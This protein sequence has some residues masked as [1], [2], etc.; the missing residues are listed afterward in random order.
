MKKRWL[1]AVLACSF[2]L[3]AVTAQA[4][5]V[6]Y[7]SKTAQPQ[8]GESVTASDS[9]WTLRSPDGSISMTVNLE[10][11]GSLT[12]GAYLDG[13]PFI[14]DGS[15]L[16]LKGDSWDL[17]TGLQFTDME[18]TTIDE[19]YE[20][21]SGKFSQ[22]N[23]SANQLSLT[24]TK[25]SVP[26]EL[27]VEARAYDD[28]VAFRYLVNGGDGQLTVVDETSS[29]ITPDNA[30]TW[31]FGAGGGGFSYE[32][33][34]NENTV[35][36]MNGDYAIP[37]MYEAYDDTYVLINEANL[38]TSDFCGSMASTSAGSTEF[39]IQF[40]K[41]QGSPV[42]TQMPFA[43]PWRYAVAGEMKTVYENTM[44][45]NL[46][47][48]P[49]ED[50]YHYSE[51]VEPGIVSWTWLAE[52]E[53][54]EGQQNIEAVKEYIDMAATLGWKYF[55]W[56]DGWQID[57]ANNSMGPEVQEVIDYA[58]ERGIGILVWVNEDYLDT[59]EERESRFSIWSEM[60]IKGIKA[61][62]FDGEHQ[63]EI[64]EYRAIYEDLAKYHMIGI[65]HGCNKPTGDTRTYPNILSR[66]AVRGDEFIN[67]TQNTTDH[68][69]TAPFIRGAVGPADYTPIF[70][71]EN[72][73]TGQPL[74]NGDATEAH[75]LMITVLFE[76]GLPCMADKCETYMSSEARYFLDHLPASWD[77]TRYLD[78][79]VGDHITLARR[80]GDAW[81]LVSN[82]NENARQATFD[83]ADFLQPGQTY[84][85]EI[86]RDGEGRFDLVREVIEVTAEDTI[87]VDLMAHGGCAIKVHQPQA[88]TNVTLEDTMVSLESGE[89]YPMTF[90]VEPDDA[91]VLGLEWTSSDPEV[92]QVRSDGVVTAGRAGRAIITVKEANTG[93]S[94]TCLVM[95]EEPDYVLDSNRWTIS[96]DTDGI[97]VESEN[98]ITM[99]MKVGELGQYT[100][101][102]NVL[103]M[104]APQGDFTAVVQINNPELT[105]NYQTIALA[106]YANNS[107]IIATMRRFHG[108]LG[109]N[110]FAKLNYNGQYDE[111]KVEDTQKTGA[112]WLKLER[113][114]D[115]FIHS[116]S[117]NGTDWVEI[118]RSTNNPDVTNCQDLKIALYTGTGQSGAT[119]SDIVFENLT[120]NGQAVS[121]AVEGEKVEPTK[122]TTVETLAPVTVD[123]GTAFDALGLPETVTVTVDFQDY[124]LDVPVT[125][126]S[127]D[128]NADKPGQQVISGTLQLPEGLENP[129]GHAAQVTVEVRGDVEEADKSL[130]EYAYSYALEQDA[131]NLIPTVAAKFE[132]AMAN[133]KAVLDD[134]NVSQTEVNAAFDQLVEAIHMLDFTRGDKT[135]LGLLIDRADGMMVEADKYVTDTWQQL[136]DALAKAKDVYADE[137]AMDS[138]IQPVVDELLSAILAQRFK[139]DKS[140]LEDLIGEAE[141]MDLNGYTAE[142][143]E[144]FRTALANAQAVMADNSLS[145]DDQNVVDQAVA[146]LTAAMNG[147]TAEGTPEATDKP[148]T[149]DKPEA[150]DKPQAT[151]KPENNVPQTGDHSQITLWVTMMSLCAA[152]ALILVAVKGRRK[153]K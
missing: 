87:T 124:T 93:V 102:Q 71:L 112:A 44:A 80:S 64:Q 52:G 69:T 70:N 4:A 31:S 18:E 85:A 6:Q 144:V 73:H 16:G 143:V 106:A 84:Q 41:T 111:G 36:N 113:Q 77:E 136:V 86:Y 26:Y 99:D 78:G 138:E 29:F 5:D 123:A 60:G 82:A 53:T 13:N 54:R 141:G 134:V 59:P 114:G 19:T 126:N 118:G 24:F 89:R 140:I 38:M 100:N 40:V 10:E 122:V 119:V 98:R 63:S 17:S 130:L 108:G 139:A 101:A 7:L 49:D 11:D 104:D 91:S 56:D 146:Q 35:N 15:Q 95:V 47:D 90:A 1:A 46:S 12:Y 33:F 34:F 72:K 132:A 97:Q 149:T 137:D 107:R 62:F 115:T 23:N 92:A 88:I 135:M 67:R 127:Q 109:G 3:S 66:E 27:T 21:L 152:S 57:P 50:T 116:Y 76:S 55:L 14:C 105:S 20:M 45:E 148:E 65:M 133:A 39:N 129:D 32:E 25:E 61:D 75:Q 58:A 74:G 83:M 28:G 30:K 142:S 117:Y 103:L 51:W 125:W 22:I 42:T 121:F 48:A 150:T 110:V 79:E 145:E 9:E 2:T 96:N 151:Q 43:S 147:L 68:T 153:A 8:Q 131:S 37:L 120:V 94:D 81:Y 128:Y